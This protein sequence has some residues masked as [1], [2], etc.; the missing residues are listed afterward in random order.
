MWIIKIRP[1]INAQYD[2]FSSILKLY[3]HRPNTEKTFTNSP[4]PS[5]LT[6]T[7][8][9]STPQDPLNNTHLTTILN[10]NS[11]SNEICI[12][13]MNLVLQKFG[14]DSTKFR[15]M[16]LNK[17]EEEMLLTNTVIDNNESPT[18][19]Q[20]IGSLTRKARYS[21]KKMF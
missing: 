17:Y 1:Q 2:H 13:D 12:P 7:T 20:R 4:Q 18:I 19:S 11:I 8:P 16:P 6:Q 5:S 14:I 3:S 21:K 9:L 15:T 10:S